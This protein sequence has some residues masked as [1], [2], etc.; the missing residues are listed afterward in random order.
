MT[1]RTLLLER[2]G[3]LLTDVICA[4]E[5]RGCMRFAVA[6]YMYTPD[7]LDQFRQNSV[8]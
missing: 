8:S 6:A 5:T 3:R 1:E 4:M 7:R 2:R